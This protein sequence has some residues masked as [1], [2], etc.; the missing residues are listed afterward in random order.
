MD[1]YD[2]V[3]FADANT[4]VKTDFIDKLF[5]RISDEG[6]KKE[7]VMDIRAD[8]AVDNPKLIEKLAKGGLKVVIC[9]FESF[10][11]KELALYNK[12]SDAKKIH[13]AIKIFND[14]GIMLRGNYVIPPDYI[15]EDFKAMAEYASSHKVTYAGYTVLTPMPGT[16]IYEEMKNNITD[17][18]L[19]KYNFFN[20]V[21]NT[22]LPKEEFYRNI[23]KLWMIKK[24]EDVI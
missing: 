10:R 16:P 6:I 11:D 9:G 22:F 17:H 5:T 24:G 13:E 4:I 20:S 19:G 14:N 18:D 23:G 3:R 7:Y 21:T 8:T 2:V 1:R 15:E 12:S